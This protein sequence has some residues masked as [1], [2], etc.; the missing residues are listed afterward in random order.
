MPTQISQDLLDYLVKSNINLG[1]FSN[2]VA[3]DIIALLNLAEADIIKQIEKRMDV[4]NFTGKRLEAL[5]GEIRAMNSEA[6]A[7]MHESLKQEMI[8]FAVHSG[9][10]AA[11]TLTSQVPLKW[12]VLRVSDDQLRA[13]VSDVAI[14]VGEGKK[15]LFGEIFEA[16][17]KSQDDAVR[18]A[19]RLGMIEGEG[20][21][22]MVRRLKGT[23]A[24][25]YKDGILEMPRRHLETMTRTIVNSVSNSAVQATFA[26]NSEVVK[27]WRFISTMDGKTSLTCRSLSNTKWPIGQGPIPPRHPNCRSFAAPEIATWKELGFDDMPEYPPAKRSSKNGLIDANTSMDSWMRSQPKADIVEMLGP[28]RAELFLKGGMKVD[29]FADNKGIV[30]TLAELK[31]RNGAMFGKVFNN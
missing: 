22:Q 19:I 6:Y 7:G 10:V 31:K 9:E 23:K 11:L 24:N 27:A 15:L 18:G 30:Y 3:S 28:K 26:A 25:Q 13:I 1:R 20:I 4:K 16:L 5:L 2:K 29:S 14:T 12:D 8:P 17:S 21:P